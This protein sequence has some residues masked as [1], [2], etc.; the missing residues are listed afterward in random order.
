[1]SS[2]KNTGPGKE[3]AAGQKLDELIRLLHETTLSEAEAAEYKSRFDRAL[4]NATIHNQLKAY[5]QLD[6]ADLTRT[7]MLNE[8]SRL[9]DATNLDSRTI[10]H[11]KKKRW[12]SGFLKLVIGIILIILGYAMIVLPAPPNFEMYT[13]F[14]FT[15]DDGVTIMDVISLLIVLTGIY[16]IVTATKN[17]TV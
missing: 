14:Y 13:L 9:L 16:L 15:P 8:L 5:E 11:Y 6:A 7:E 1:M 10:K 4:E 17:K 12:A 2:K 3:S